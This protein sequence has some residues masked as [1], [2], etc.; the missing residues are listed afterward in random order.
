MTPSYRVLVVDDEEAI[1][2]II[3]EV[4]T[5]H[6]HICETASNGYEA[7]AKMSEWRPDAVITDIVMPVM[8]GI[9][10]SKE[11][12]AR[13][14]DLPVMIITAFSAEYQE[15]DVIRFGASDFIK[16]PFNI[17]EL[18]YRFVRMMRDAETLKM[19][20]AHSV[21][22]NKRNDR[23]IEDLLTENK[24]L[25]GEIK[26][27]EKYAFYDALTGIPNRRLFLERLDFVLKEA[28][29]Y[30]LMFSLLFLDLDDFKSVNDSMGHDMGDLVLKEVAARLQECVREVDMVARYGGDEF[31]V[32]LTRIDHW[33]D[34]KNVAQRVVESIARPMT[35]YEC[36]CT[37]RASV[38][39]SLYPNDG[40]DGD[41]IIKRADSAMY[42]AKR[43]GI[44]YAFHAIPS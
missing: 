7:L 37:I 22:L 20:K 5:S 6:G 42:N 21:E 41:T 15:D 4:L 23:I 36:E 43:K 17:N 9:S 29:R 2:T 11:I 25:E 14:S 1:R 12:I 35:F 27:I 18:F 16:K 13:Y 30:N 26:T 32:I 10:L 24:T 38:G 44:N 8:D 34:A 39:I 33:L 19:L 31:T 3:C 28:R 40:E